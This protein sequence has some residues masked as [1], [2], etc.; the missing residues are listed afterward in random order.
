M[1]NMTHTATA[2]ESY[3][4]EMGGAHDGKA[5][6]VA[7]SACDYISW[8]PERH[9]EALAT[10]KRLRVRPRYMHECE[11]IHGTKKWSAV[12]TYAAFCKLRPLLVREALLD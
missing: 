5:L 6:F 11:T 7:A 2:G 9:A 3:W 10:F 12:I 1:T 8:K 4:P